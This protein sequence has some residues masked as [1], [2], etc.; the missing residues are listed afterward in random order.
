MKGNAVGEVQYGN[1]VLHLASAHHGLSALH[2]FRYLILSTALDNVL[3]F[4]FY[5]KRS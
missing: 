4:L 5:R 1:L 2:P 3:L